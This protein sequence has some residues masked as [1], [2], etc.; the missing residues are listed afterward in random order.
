MRNTWFPRCHVVTSDQ[1]GKVKFHV[2]LSTSLPKDVTKLSIKVSIFDSMWN[3]NK[4]NKQKL[5]F[6]RQ[7]PWT[8]RQIMPLE[9]RSPWVKTS[10]QWRSTIEIFTFT[11]HQNN[12]DRRW[13]FSL[14]LQETKHDVS[15]SHE[16]GD[17]SLGLLRKEN[18]ALPCDKVL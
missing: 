15:L 7:R 2:P 3:E 18:K 4:T 9:W 11:F 12:D 10:E 13:K 8:R 17:L 5:L 1:S 6:P 16:G 14:F